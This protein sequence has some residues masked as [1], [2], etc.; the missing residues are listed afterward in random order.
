MKKGLFIAALLVAATTQSFA[1]AFNN[2]WVQAQVYPA[3]KGQVFIDWYVDEVNY[4]PMS[5][6]KR[7]TNSAES[8]AYIYAKPVEGWLYAGVA[9]DCNM[10]G[11]YEVGTDRPVHIWWNHFFTAFYDHTPYEVPG[12]SSSSYELAQEALET[13]TQPTDRVFAI[14]TQGAVAHR[15]KGEEARG[16]VFCDKLYNEPGDEVTFFAYGDS[17]YTDEGNKYYKFDH[18][19]DADGNPVSTDREFKITVKGMETYYAHFVQT[20]KADNKE[21]EVVPDRWKYDYNNPD[22][23]PTGIQNVKTVNSASTAVYD[24]LGRRV[25]QPAKGLYIQ[26]GKKFV[27]K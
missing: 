19:A 26:N 17:E 11:T 27:K 1:Q 9:R 22:W 14:F 20:T 16:Y 7:S 24:L 8:A 6:F 21:N 15:A 25:A 3:E 13:M 4:A 23:D 10:N 2:I 5:Q 12:S 18:W